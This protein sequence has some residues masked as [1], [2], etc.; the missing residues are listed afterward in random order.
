[1]T[2]FSASADDEGTPIDNDHSLE[3]QNFSSY[4]VGPVTT[5]GV[6]IDILKLLKYCNAKSCVCCCCFGVFVDGA[7]VARSCLSLSRQLTLLLFKV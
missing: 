3:I 6:E 2:R 1:M 4:F 7:A 5:A